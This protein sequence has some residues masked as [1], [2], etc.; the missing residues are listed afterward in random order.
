MPDNRP[1]VVSEPIL[2]WLLEGDPA[3]R[4]QTKRDLLN[5]PLDDVAAERSRVA[6]SGWGHCCW[7]ERARFPSSSAS[8]K[9]PIS[10]D[11]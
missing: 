7:I 4:W 8:A 3:I 11:S 5:S 6:N 9:V 10:D 2:D 1:D